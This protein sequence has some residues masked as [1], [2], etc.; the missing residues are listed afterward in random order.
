MAQYDRVL[1]EQLVALRQEDF[2]LFAR[3]GAE[4][5]VLGGQLQSASEVSGADANADE[6]DAA[7]RDLETARLI[8][9]IRKQS[10][11]LR[12]LDQEVMGTLETQRGLLRTEVSKVRGPVSNGAVR[13]MQA[14]S[15]TDSDRLDIVL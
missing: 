13:Y 10:N 12:A 15:G 3:L 9:E 2:D 4:R 5:D 7:S 1:K 11:D 8:A 6:T 14:E